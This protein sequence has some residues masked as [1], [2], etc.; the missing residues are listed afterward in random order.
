[1]H[2]DPEHQPNFDSTALRT[3]YIGPH[4]HAELAYAH[5]FPG[6]AVTQSGPGLAMNY[7]LGSTTFTF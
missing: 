4:V 6:R 1:M 5:F 2:G 3:W 7:V